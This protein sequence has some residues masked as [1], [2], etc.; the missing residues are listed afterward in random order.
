MRSSFVA[1]LATAVFWSSPALATGAE[2]ARIQAH[3]SGAE[4]EVRRRDVAHLDPG[5]QARRARL[6]ELLA[7]YRTRGV[8]PKNPDFAWPMPYFVDAAGTRC[9][10]AELI[11]ATGGEA[12]VEEIALV[13]NNAFVPELATDPRLVAWLD[14][15]GLSLGEATR[16]Q[17]EYCWPIASQVCVSPPQAVQSIF[18]ARQAGAPHGYVVEE[19]LRVHPEQPVKPGDAL[20][21]PNAQQ[22]RMLVAG[23]GGQWRRTWPLDERDRLH[24]ESGDAC[25]GSLTLDAR[26]AAE[27]IPAED[28][29][30]RLEVMDPRWAGLRCYDRPPCPDAGVPAPPRDAGAGDEADAGPPPLASER[31]PAHCQDAGDAS[32]VAWW[33]LLAMV[34]RLWR[35]RAAGLA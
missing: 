4:E 34:P 5:Q 26:L 24:F 31:M 13:D 10:M 27:L 30:D 25:E 6:M 28:C 16:I 8:F 11:H 17:P 1:T 7:A 2:R 3:L 29:A 19:V 23:L 35:R 14:H 20:E 12:L 15:H 9:A 32:F 18:I 21:L 33:V 22:P